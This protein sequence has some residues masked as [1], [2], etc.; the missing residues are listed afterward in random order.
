MDRRTLLLAAAGAALLP[1][2]AA[3]QGAA[4]NLLPAARNLFR[5]ATVVDCNITPPIWG[6]LPLRQEQLD[7]ARNSGITATKSTIGGFGNNFEDT[8]NQL[9]GY[10][11]VIEYHPDYYM[12]IRRAAD[13]ETAKRTNKL[14]I[15]FSFEGVAM[16]DGQVDRISLFRNLGVMVMQLSYNLVSPFGSGVLA[17]PPTG[18]TDLGRQAVAKMNEEGVAIDVSHANP[19]TTAEAMEASTKPVLMTHG[20]CTAVH[21]HPRNKTDEQLRALAEQGGVFGIYDLPYLTPSPRQPTLDDYIA[22]MAH[23][24]DVA[25][26]EHVGIGSDTSFMGFDTSPEGMAQFQRSIEERRRA[27]VGAPGEDRP[28]YVEGMN[29]HYRCQII[30]DALLRRGYPA[31]VTEKVLGANFLRAFRDIW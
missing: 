26:E 18:L 21:A 11:R 29:T 16:L 3:A 14:G 24:L 13:I 31:R 7:A 23:A 20:G 12:Q 9:S 10:Q 17:D 22:H 6:E 15:I 27:G 8:L 1:A 30:A 19:A 2:V 28:V 25:G 5:R 4:P